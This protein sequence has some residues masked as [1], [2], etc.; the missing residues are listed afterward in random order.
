MSD[1]NTDDLEYLDLDSLLDDASD[2]NEEETAEGTASGQ[3]AEAD[4]EALVSDKAASRASLSD[5][6]MQE[7]EDSDEEEEYDEEASDEMSPASAGRR[8]AAATDRRSATNAAARNGRNPRTARRGNDGSR[9]GLPGWVHLVLLGAIAAIALIAFVRYQRW[10]KGEQIVIDEDSAG[11]F[12]VE[13]NDNMVLLPA[14]KL[15]GHEDDGKTT[16]LCLGNAPFSDDT[17]EKGLAGQISQLSGAETINAS[18]PN[19]QVTCYNR[20]YDTSTNRGIHDIFNLFYVCYAI[21]INDYTSLET[22][23]SVHTEDPQYMTAVEN[24]KNTDFNKVDI[25]AVMYD[26]IDYENRMAVTNPNLE[27]ELDTYTGSLKNAFQLIQDKY[28]HIRIVFM[29]PTYMMHKDE[30]GDYKDGRTDDIGNGTLIQYWQFGYDTCGDSGVSF[31]DNYYGSINDTNYKEYLSDNIHINDAGR[32]K[33]ADHF[34]YKVL[35]NEYA[36][37]DAGSLAIAGK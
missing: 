22:V 10:A 20:S 34:V 2:T 13:V 23:A 16:I 5:G 4:E 1:H 11:K 37:Y 8:S 24:L 29:S 35:N 18:F 7:Q 30:N 17:S 12:N 6:P 28:P 26:A 9:T 3:E 33:I 31:L 25:I 14:S 27:D 15:E 32:T 19:S 36:E 21:S